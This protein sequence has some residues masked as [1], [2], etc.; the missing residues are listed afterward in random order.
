MLLIERYEIAEGILTET[1]AAHFD[2]LVWIPSLQTEESTH[3]YLELKPWD[4]QG[5]IHKSGTLSSFCNQSDLIPL[6]AKWWNKKPETVTEP[7]YKNEFA[8]WFENQGFSIPEGIEISRAGCLYAMAITQPHL[9]ARK[10]CYL[11]NNE[12]QFLKKCGLL[13]N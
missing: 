8:E 13:T 5:L 10:A 1:S 4:T 7:I 3:S 2:I 6:I 12:I 9:Q 11:E